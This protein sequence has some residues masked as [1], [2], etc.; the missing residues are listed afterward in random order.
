[1]KP[2]TNGA[3]LLRG[4]FTALA[5]V[6]LV[7]L[8][9]LAVAVAAVPL[10]TR[11]QSL[12]VNDASMAPAINEG[13]LVVT[14][15]VSDPGS[16]GLGQLV[17]FAKGGGDTTLAIRE[18]VGEQLTAT[19]RRLITKGEAYDEP[20]ESSLAEEDVIGVYMYRIPKLGYAVEWAE[21]HGLTV[22]VILSVLVVLLAAGLVLLVL[23][24]R[25]L[26]RETRPSETAPPS[27]PPTP[28]PTAAPGPARGPSASPAEDT[29]PFAR[30]RPPAPLASGAG[31]ATRG[32][33]RP[34]PP[35]PPSPPSPLAR[36]AAPRAG[37]PAMRRSSPAD[38]AAARREAGAEPWE[39]SPDAGPPL[40]SRRSVREAAAARSTPRRTD[41]RQTSAE[42]APPKPRPIPWVKDS[43]APTGEIPPTLTAGP[44][45]WGDLQAVTRRQA[46]TRRAVT[47]DRIISTRPDTVAKPV[48]FVPRGPGVEGFSTGELPT[49]RP[50]HIGEIKSVADRL[51]RATVP[52]GGMPRPWGQVEPEPRPPQPR[53][54][55]SL[56]D[57]IPRAQTPP[58]PL[59]PPEPDEDLSWMDDIGGKLRPWDAP[60]P[61]R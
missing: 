42:G 56:A 23:R 11:G 37:Q 5:G 8:L 7:A 19:G 16:V 44:P 50:R 2:P 43:G 18:V 4:Y 15:G 40:L 14:R 25:R 35:S 26:P 52:P 60:R 49:R 9:A 48:A 38:R 58:W 1:M 59:A 6:L 12:S 24:Q 28:E 46:A 39:S 21:K 47:A 32:P 3:V 34:P 20:D 31:A 13:D 33:R 53:R 17:V 55:S 54:A 36:G 10:I 45:N 27:A 22:I 30:R 61:T 29:G 41:P 51:P 57:K